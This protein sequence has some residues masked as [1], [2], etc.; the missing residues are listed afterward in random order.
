[1]T[2]EI[3]VPV[4]PESVPDATISAVSVKVN[5]TVHEGA[6]LFEL[7]TDKIMIEV[8]ATNAGKITDLKVKAGDQ[9]KSDEL[10]CLIDESVKPVDEPKSAE[11]PAASEAKET[12][13]P[14]PKEAPAPQPDAKFEGTPSVRR[15]AM[16]GHEQ[17]I[18]PSITASR[19]E[20]RV[21]MTR[22]RKT[23]ADRLIDAQQSTA[24]LTTFNEVDMHA[25]MQI[26]NENKKAFEAFYG[27]RLGFMSFF[28]K[29]CCMAL[30]TYPD[31]NASIDGDDLIYRDY[32]DIGIAVSTDRGLVVPVLRDANLMNMA[33][34]EK[35][36]AELAGKAR[37]GKLGLEDMTGGTFS[38]TNAGKFGSLLSTPILNPP[39]AAILGMHNIIERPVV[40]NGEMVIRPMMY[41]ALTYDH[42]IIDGATSVQFLMHVKTLLEDPSKMLLDL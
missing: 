4:L 1:M 27:V 8:P 13:A 32:Q 34:M 14:A 40:I 42:R 31:V 6:V 9:V 41:I 21:P 35:G 25:V 29:A 15:A 10:L 16:L 19:I 30:Q 22:I 26:R 39:Q 7:E 5:D 38:I 24:A 3:R 33:R 37:D 28:I 18:E 2:I 12:P 20:K 23:I 17:R 36:V 11:A